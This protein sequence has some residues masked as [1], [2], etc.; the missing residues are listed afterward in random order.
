MV[1]KKKDILQ[2]MNYLKK[3][4]GFT[5]I[6]LLVVI[7]IIGVL[8]TF[9][10]SSLGEARIKANNTA[11]LTRIKAIQ[12]ALELYHLDNGYYPTASNDPNYS[13]WPGFGSLEGFGPMVID[14]HNAD[15]LQSDPL[16]AGWSLL[17]AELG[18]YTSAVNGS[19]AGSEYVIIY[20]VTGEYLWTG[21][22]GCNEYTPDTYTILFSTNTNFPGIEEASRSGSF[23]YN[24][25]IYSY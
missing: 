2:T 13:S 6:E 25:C 8:A 1:R 22:F 24:Y 23:A 14:S 3:R 11:Q 15:T 19:Q 21:A 12:Q 17:E 20:G 5:L 10:L 7:S 9:V 18:P 4:N 16:Y